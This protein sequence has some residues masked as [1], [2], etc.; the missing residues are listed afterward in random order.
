MIKEKIFTLYKVTLT[1]HFVNLNIT[2]KLYKCKMY[3]IFEFVI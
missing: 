2:D 1:S 3:N